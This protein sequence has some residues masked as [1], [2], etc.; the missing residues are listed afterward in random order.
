MEILVCLLLAAILGGGR[1]GADIVHAVK[2]TTPPHLEKARLKAQQQKKT[3]RERSPYAEGKPRIKDVAAVYWGDAMA[4]AIKAHNRRRAE[5]AAQ[6][7]EN[8]RAVAAGEEPTRVRP[9]LKDRAKR[10]WRLLIDPVGEKPESPATGSTQPSDD[11]ERPGPA[12]DGRHRRPSDGPVVEPDAGATPSTATEGDKMPITTED[13]AQRAKD[14]RATGETAARATTEG[15][16]GVAPTGEAVNYETALAELDR[17][18]EAQRTHL[19]STQVALTKVQ[20]AKAA[21]SDSQ[22]NYRPAAEAAGSAHQ[23]LS[24]LNLDAETTA[25]TGTM[26]DAMPPNRVD[27]MF[28]QL[29]QMEADAQ[30]QVVNAEAALASTDSARRVIVGKYGDAHSTVQG[31]LAGDS[32]FLAG[33]GAN[34]A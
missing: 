34:A 15:G 28:A 24:A 10:W 31:E 25:H 8:E 19:D 9:S 29:E 2:G 26:V 21:I 33:S 23:H 30:Q 18:E 1:I 4:D 27:E 20:E 32:R 11:E 16:G 3:P 14:T 5:K 6:R 22:A 7:A 17:I 13:A 12:S